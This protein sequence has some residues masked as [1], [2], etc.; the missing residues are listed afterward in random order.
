M[1]SKDLFDLLMEKF[2]GEVM[3]DNQWRVTGSKGDHY[4]VTW[5]PYQRKYSCNCKGHMFRKKCSHVTKLSEGFR[6]RV[7]G[8]V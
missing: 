1:K 3:V 7:Q 5:D 6:K 2:D 8:A 4:T